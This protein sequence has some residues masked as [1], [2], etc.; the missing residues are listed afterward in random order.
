MSLT[1]R[2]SRKPYDALADMGYERKDVMKALK[3]PLR[4]NAARYLEN[5]RKGPD[6]TNAVR[7]HS[8]YVSR[9]EPLANVPEM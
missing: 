7:T 9:S 2:G 5:N 1:W 3:L 4:D 8:G 6:N